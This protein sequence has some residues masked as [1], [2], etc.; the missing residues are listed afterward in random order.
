MS[1]LEFMGF[2]IKAEATMDK[3]AGYTNIASEGSKPVYVI[4]TNEA[5]YMIQKAGEMLDA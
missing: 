1:K 3:S 5:A 4:P 2:K